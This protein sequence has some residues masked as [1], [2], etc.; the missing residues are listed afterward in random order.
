VLT[1]YSA[2]ILLLQLRISAP[3]WH[4]VPQL[5]FLQFPWRF[6]AMQSAVTV[7]LLCLSLQ[8]LP[9]WIAARTHR[10][11]ILAVIGVA[12]AALA[13]FG[14]ADH[15]FRQGCD[16]SEGLETQRAAF[17]HGDAYEETDEYNPV[18]ADSDE[19][20][21]QLPHAWLSSTAT[22]VPSQETGAATS[23]T[24]LPQESQ[25]KPNDLFFTA[26]GTAANSFLIV[27][28]RNFPGWHILRDGTELT[29]LPHR[30]DGLIVIPLSTGMHHVEIQY[31]TTTD[32]YMGGGLTITAI[33]ILL[34]VARD[35]RRR[36]TA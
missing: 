17:L 20:K 3:V 26:T 2:L 8:K 11:A 16:D 6:L 30:L 1:V 18:G 24:A 31:R 15:A 7:T 13:G 21:V 9:T 32:Q 22:G 4:I 27:R 5:V 23:T 34:G 14:L 10:I 35:E 36:R 12:A 28:L 29:A 19:L 25:R 33:V